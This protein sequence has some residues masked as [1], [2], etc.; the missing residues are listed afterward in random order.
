MLCHYVTGILGLEELV[1]M[2]AQSVGC[3]LLEQFP[4]HSGSTDE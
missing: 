2:N 4:L 3:L 1:T